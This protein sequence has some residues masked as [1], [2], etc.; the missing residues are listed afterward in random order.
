MA[1][2]N[3]ERNLSCECDRKRLIDGQ[4]S[5]GTSRQFRRK[6]PKASSKQRGLESFRADK[7]SVSPVTKCPAWPVFQNFSSW[8]CTIQN[9][10]SEVETGESPWQ[11]GLSNNNPGLSQLDQLDKCESKLAAKHR[12]PKRRVSNPFQASGICC[13]H[14]FPH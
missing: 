5:H 3:T 4:A 14:M 7:A 12:F 9:V 10:M 6:L 8:L 2:T 11:H 13:F 1:P